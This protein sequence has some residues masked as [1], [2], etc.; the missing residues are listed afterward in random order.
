MLL[1]GWE[2]SASVKWLRRIEVADAPFMSREETSKYTEA[3][4]GGRGRMFSFV[5]DARSIITFPAY[6]IQLQRGWVEIRGLA[7]SGRGTIRHVEISTDSGRS[8]RPA[9][10]QPPVLSKAHTRFRHLW[11]WSGEETQI[12]SRVVDETG[13]RQPSGPELIASRGRGAGAYH[14]NTI[15]AWRIRGNGEVVFGVDERWMT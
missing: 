11:N 5:M 2:G 7:W 12:M 10:L 8:W 4:H 15:V 13:Y 6:P 1:P 9:E 14:M 3:M